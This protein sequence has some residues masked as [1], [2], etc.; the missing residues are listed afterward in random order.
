MVYSFEV[1]FSINEYF[2]TRS[3]WLLCRVIKIFHVFYYN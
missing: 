3:I 2:G 1:F